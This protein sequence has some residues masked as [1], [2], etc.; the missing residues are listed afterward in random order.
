MSPFRI[1]RVR[2]KSVIPPSGDEQLK[3]YLDRLL[4]M[5][6]SEV[7]GLYLVGT[8]FI[9]KEELAAAL[10]WMVVCLIAVFVVRIY[11][12]SDKAINKGPQWLSI[13]LAALAFL[14]WTYSLGGPFVTIGI[15][16]PYLGSLL[17]LAWSFFVPILYKGD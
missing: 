13:V 15:H 3:S 8:G 12:T 6:P 4:K 17:I 7:I 14:I 1:T 2:S 11:G 10:V 5:I 9:P 16:R